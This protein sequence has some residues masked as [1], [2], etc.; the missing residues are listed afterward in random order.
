MGVS[1]SSNGRS[2]HRQ[3]ATT[4]SRFHRVLVFTNSIQSLPALILILLIMVFTGMIALVWQHDMRLPVW[5]WYF[6]ATGLNWGLLW[7][8]PRTGRSYGPDRPSA[9]ALAVVMLVP[10]LAAGLVRAPAYAAVG[11]LMVVTRLNFYATWMEPFRLRVTHQTYTTPKW[12]QDAPPLRILHIGDIH[13]ERITPRERRLN[14]LIETLKPEVIVF[15]GDF[16]NLSYNQDETAKTAVREVIAA[17]HAPLG[18]YCVPGT[19]AVE[20]VERVQEFVE[21]LPALRLL[22]NESV[23]LSTPAGLLT[24]FGTLTTHDMDTD[25]ASFARVMEQ[26]PPGEALTLLLT[27]APDLALEA[28]TAGIDLYF[29]GHTHGGQ[30]RFPFIGALFSASHLGMRFVIGRCDLERT[31][32]YTTRGVGLEGLGAPRA[33]FLCPPEIILWELKGNS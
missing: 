29:C 9:L 11:L 15:S 20:S 19:P 4:E 16:V 17:W 6:G 30:I 25:R 33:R 22:L 21:A 18:V 1:R 24:I 7:L 31:T 8:L 28:D 13:V 14:Q 10:M 26:S 5:L 23:T 27:H 12:K 2:G 32:V 3:D